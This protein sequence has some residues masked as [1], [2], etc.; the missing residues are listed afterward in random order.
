MNAA[1]SDSDVKI[2]YINAFAATN[3]TPAISFVPA[4]ASVLPGG[5]KEYEIRV[6]SLPKGLA[7]Y[8]LVCT[9]SNTS[10]AE[11]ISVSYPSW[12]GLRNTTN[13]SAWSVRLS[14]VDTDRQIQ[15]GAVNVI[16]ANMT[17]KGDMA[18]VTPIVISN[19]H[20][21]ADGGDAINSSTN[22]GQLIVQS[23]TP[24]PPVANFTGTPRS[25]NAPL[26]VQFTDTS[27][28]SPT[29]WAWDFNNDGVIDN[30]SRNPMYTYLSPGTY[31]VNLTVT[32][33]GGSDSELKMNY[34]S[35][36]S[37]PP[38]PPVANFTGTPRSGNAPLSVQFIDTSTGSPT[39]WAW[40]FNND[41]VIDNTSRNPMYTYLSP[42]TYSVNLTVTNAGGSDSELKTNYVSVHSPPPA[43]PVANFTGTPR[44]GNA[45]LSVQFTDTSTG[46]PTSWAW[47][48]NNDGVIDNT[49]RNP[50][51][52]YLSPGTYSVNLTVTN[53]GGSDNELKMNYVSVHSP[54]PAPPVANFTGTPRLGNAPLS[55]QF[56]DT[57][58]GSPTS[59]A[60][61]FNNDGVI[62]NTSRNPIYTYPS[63]GTYSVNLTVTNEG[64]SDS[65]LK[66]NY[67]TV[68]A[69]PPAPPVANFSGTPRSGNA[70]LSVQFTDTSSG[71]PT[72]W[73]WDFNN[74]GVI[75]NTS[76]NP[77][78]TYPNPGT[79]S[80][81][82]TVTN[83]GGSDSEL[84][85]NYITVLTP[86]PAPP[87]ANFTGTP[88]SGNAPL[89]VQ[90]TDTSSGSPTSWAWDFNNDGVIDNTS[91]NPSYT[92]PNPGTYSVNLTVTNAGGS[93]SELKTNYISVQATPSG[94]ASVSGWVSTGSDIGSVYVPEIRVRF[95]TSVSDLSNPDHYW[96]A[97]TDQRGTYSISGLPSGVTLYAKALSP[98][99]RPNA[100]LER[101][102]QYEVN[103]GRLIT[104]QN[105]SSTPQ[106]LPIA[107]DG[108]IQVNWVL[109]Q[110]PSAFGL[111]LL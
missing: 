33:A 63:P 62:D 71:S 89:S 46:S 28:G 27:T 51:Y 108:K 13:Y 34:I 98:V 11:I 30:T 76:R 23:L 78:Y 84:K 4:S 58:T 74:D 54:P 6:D 50:I 86:P 44:S 20:M 92:Y 25:G 15:P 52:T 68:Q 101:P 12:A 69:P 79:Y 59:W 57:S 102:I 83:A 111:L 17:L 47:D 110:N 19:V 85:T 42:R 81:N 97:T 39:S 56:I 94:T 66:T 82:L 32:N 70:P 7:G 60:W 53:A 36:Q 93:D 80:V 90:F 55:V 16:L 31:S 73:A 48:F 72:S 106:V 29:S 100:Y 49:S 26:L 41:G 18:G 21:D 24:A 10:V 109:T 105:I 3:T 35:V 45:P 88:R 14:G 95:A 96:E 91:R 22:N 40:D 65:E 8:D 87:V 64:G 107:L 5:S 38:A 61:D 9:V 67:I 75:D 103:S 43:P 2:G 77:M 1:G 99:A 104:C 37:P